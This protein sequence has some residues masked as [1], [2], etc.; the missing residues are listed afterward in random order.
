MEELVEYIERTPKARHASR[1]KHY[2][3]SL[4]PPLVEAKAP[5]TWQPAYS[6]KAIHASLS[7]VRILAYNEKVVS[8]FPTPSYDY[9]DFLLYLNHS[10]YIYLVKYPWDSGVRV[11]PMDLLHVI[12]GN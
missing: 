11:L 7:H 12:E 2:L 5:K 8:I 9:N 10:F 6:M 1:W 4:P 3:R